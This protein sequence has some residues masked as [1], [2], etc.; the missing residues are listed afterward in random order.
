MLFCKW[1]EVNLMIG[2]FSDN[3]V[4]DLLSNDNFI[5][6][7]EIIED[8]FV[9]DEDSYTESPESAWIENLSKDDPLIL[10]PSVSN[11]LSTDMTGMSEIDMDDIFASEELYTEQINPVHVQVTPDMLFESLASV[12]PENPHTDVIADDYNLQ[13]LCKELSIQ[14][15][16]TDNIRDMNVLS[17]IKEYAVRCDVLE[18]A[19]MEPFIQKISEQCFQIMDTLAASKATHRPK[20]SHLNEFRANVTN[21]TDKELAAIQLVAINCINSR[22]ERLAQ[23]YCIT[24]LEP[25]MICVENIIEDLL[26]TG[27]VNSV[28]LSYYM[29]SIVTYVTTIKSIIVNDYKN[30]KLSYTREIAERQAM[31]KQLMNTEIAIEK[32]LRESLGRLQLVH[33]MQRN[34]SGKLYVKCSKC[35]TLHALHSAPMSFIY[36]P[37]E[38][39]Y[40][41]SFSPLIEECTCGEIFIFPLEYYLLVQKRYMTEYKTELK[42]VISQSSES[43]SGAAFLR[44]TPPFSVLESELSFLITE[45]DTNI[46]GLQKTEMHNYESSTVSIDMSM[47]KMA[48]HQFYERLGGFNSEKKLLEHNCTV[49]SIV[50]CQTMAYY[51]AQCTGHRYDELKMQAFY[52]LLTFISENALLNKALN[53]N[54]IASLENKLIV[55]Q[56]NNCDFKLL[57][58]IA[59]GDMLALCYSL[60][61]EDRRIVEDAYK[62]GR[63]YVK[64]LLELKIAILEEQIVKLRKKRLEIITDLEQCIVPLSFCKIVHYQSCPISSVISYVLDERIFDLLNLVSDRMIINNYAGEFY[65]YWRKLNI[66]KKSVLTSV[67]V[68]E[69]SKTNV[70][71]RI[72]KILSDKLYLHTTN[73]YE[74]FGMCFEM[75]PIQQEPFHRITTMIKNCNYYKFCAELLSIQN[76]SKLPLGMDYCVKLG[77]SISAQLQKAKEVISQ[78]EYEFYLSRDF[79]PEELRD[80]D[81]EFSMLIFGRYI[82]KR[83]THETPAEYVK[84]YNK[85][86]VDG[87][88]CT[89]EYYDNADFFDQFEHLSFISCSSLLYEM[90]YHNYMS[91]TFMLSLIYFLISNGNL[92]SVCGTLG[93]SE[94]HLYTISNC[95]TSLKFDDLNFGDNAALLRIMNGYYFTN[96]RDMMYDMF[97]NIGQIIVKPSVGLCNLSNYFSLKDALGKV[98]EQAAAAIRADDEM[99]DDLERAENEIALFIKNN[100]FYEALQLT[101][102]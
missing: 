101:G 79:T 58:D 65:N 30:D 35:G 89:D 71:D 67:F 53:G 43:S 87:S 84:R 45:L 2:I 90:Q 32:R 4:T 95:L 26:H 56:D 78:K 47:F 46:G 22:V 85:I 66:V 49:N 82:P 94:T 70:K 74:W 20:D 97:Q 7:D 64:Q 28:S 61:P 69:S 10:N 40:V 3:D 77:N 63:A 80:Y 59:Y 15:F 5:D 57:T 21:S 60:Y 1:K 9:G 31:A 96:I 13:E 38:S 19:S 99:Y 62:R 72:I 18:K 33:Q 39:G 55:I 68:T 100:S 50:N 102:A 6:S 14:G 75:S 52:S 51:V 86:A 36:F 11:K 48:V 81:E 88:I 24:E 93:L 83:R 92:E 91:S 29:D 73:Y 27:S 42:N 23:E 37:S 98:F 34:H 44:I 54:E 16:H 41:S 17:L 25:S 76:I 8:G 12:M